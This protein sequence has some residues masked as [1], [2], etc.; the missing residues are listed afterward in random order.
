MDASR[1]RPDAGDCLPGDL[2]GELIAELRDA[3]ARRVP[4]DGEIRDTPAGFAVGYPGLLGVTTQADEQR[5]D[6]R[7]TLLWSYVSCD[8][9][10]LTY[11]ITDALSGPDP[12]AVDDVGRTVRFTG[13]MVGDHRERTYGRRPDGTWGLVSEKVLSPRLL[14]AAIR[15]PAAELGW[16]ERQPASAVIGL[17]VAITAAAGVV[18]SAVVVAVLAVTGRLG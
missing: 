1:G 12:H 8:A 18:L 10:T 6:E 7:P 13:R 11:R 17:A 15:E 9:A 2:A 4:S 16:R 3:V 5:A 14:H